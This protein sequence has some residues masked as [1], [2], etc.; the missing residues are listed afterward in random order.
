MGVRGSNSTIFIFAFLLN[1]DQ[2]LKNRICSSRSKFFSL[3]VDPFLKGVIA[4]GCKQEV[5]KVASLEKIA[6]TFGSVHIHLN[7]IIR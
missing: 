1:G 6:P 4:Q 3:K 5:T 7:I 2:L